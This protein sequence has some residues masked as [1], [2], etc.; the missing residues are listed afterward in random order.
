VGNVSRG[1]NGG[2]VWGGNRKVSNNLS[3]RTALSSGDVVR[4]HVEQNPAV[5]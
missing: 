3:I 4:M 2:A 1:E 5:L